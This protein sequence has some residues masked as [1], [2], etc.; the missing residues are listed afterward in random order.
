VLL[1]LFTILLS[2]YS[3]QEDIIIGTPAAGRPHAE[4]EKLMGMFVNTLAVRNFP[5]PARTFGEF[6][7]EVKTNTLKAFENQD[8]QLEELVS[9]LGIEPNPARQ[10]LFDI[11]L[12]VQNMD[13]IERENSTGHPAKEL[14]LRSFKFGE[15]VTQFD[16]MIHA[17][18]IDGIIAFKLLYC[19]RLFKEE[20]IEMFI[21]NLRETAEAVT[22]DMDIRLGDIQISHG[23]SHPELELPRE[24][25]VF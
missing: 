3:G 13:Q 21:E 6:L 20:T 2:R 10:A 4:L 18:E 12:A 22:G 5:R 9:R 15:R 17:F 25:F 14:S 19:T 7:E 23:L 8:Y 16:M 11:M 1:A 24:D